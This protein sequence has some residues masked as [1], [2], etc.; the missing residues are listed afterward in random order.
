MLSCAINGES[1][2]FAP[3]EISCANINLLLSPFVFVIQFW[4]EVEVVSV[5]GPDCE[6]FSINRSILNQLTNYIYSNVSK[7]NDQIH[8]KVLV[9]ERN[10]VDNKVDD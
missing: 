2:V 7:D 8:I 3:T 6:M 1:S 4:A 5:V 10:A 9:R